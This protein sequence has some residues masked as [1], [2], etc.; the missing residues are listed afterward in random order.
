MHPSLVGGIRWDPHGK[1]LFGKRHLFIL[2]QGQVKEWDTHT[3]TQKVIIYRGGGGKKQNLWRVTD[4]LELE[5]I[6]IIEGSLLELQLCCPRM[7]AQFLSET[8]C[9]NIFACSDRGSWNQ[10]N[11]FH[12]LTS[13]TGRPELRDSEREREGENIYIC[14]VYYI[15]S[16][17]SPGPYI[18]GKQPPLHLKPPPSKWGHVPKPWQAQ[19][20]SC[21][22]LT[23]KQR[24]W[25]AGLSNCHLEDVAPAVVELEKS[26][27]I[28]YIFCTMLKVMHLQGFGGCIV[29]ARRFTCMLVI[30]P[31]WRL[32]SVQ[33]IWCNVTH[34]KTEVL[35]L[36]LW[37]HLVLRQRVYS[38]YLRLGLPSAYRYKDTYRLDWQL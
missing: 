26:M 1:K 32:V 35:F 11:H 10:R 8:K 16:C 36:K 3:N 15:Y 20:S 6:W 38:N 21:G 28:K 14:T 25:P 9:C 13:S 7:L 29:V 23:L 27:E 19:V 34:S 18:H 37:L 22:M 12:L 17:T 2:L 5:K 31:T 24:D 4:L 30:R 33:Y